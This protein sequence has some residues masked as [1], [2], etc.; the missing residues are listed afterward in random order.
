MDPKRMTRREAAAKLAMV[1]AAAMGLGPK[2]IERLAGQ[3]RRVAPAAKL[4]LDKLAA[5]KPLTP[6]G[7][8]LKVIIIA[9]E[10]VFA[11]EYGRGAIFGAGIP[12]GSACSFYVNFGNGSSPGKECDDNKCGEQDCPELFC[13]GNNSCGKQNCGKQVMPS[14]SDIFAPKVLDRIRMDPIVQALFKEFNVTNT[15]DLS[16]RITE[17]VSQRRTALIR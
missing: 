11:N 2:E 9:R 4:D 10:D 3:I 6:E 15:R 16:A 8:F 17:M 7:K 12:A 1:T 13:S 5:I 14:N